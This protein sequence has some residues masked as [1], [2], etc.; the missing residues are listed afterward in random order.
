MPSLGSDPGKR[1]HQASKGE[2]AS[3]CCF[4]TES[5]EEDNTEWPCKEEV[6]TVLPQIRP[7][8]YSQWY[9]RKSKSTSPAPQPAKSDPSCRQLR[10]K[11]HT[12]CPFYSSPPNHFR[13]CEEV[14]ET[15]LLCLSLTPHSA[16]SPSSWSW[17]SL[18]L[19]SSVHCMA[20]LGPPDT[21]QAR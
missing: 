1:W 11:P 14:S 13:P 5:Q 8:R 18:R 3:S 20:F 9:L 6:G 12:C 4:P 16:G 21:Q 19:S 17:C 10:E 7:V 15:C 2:E